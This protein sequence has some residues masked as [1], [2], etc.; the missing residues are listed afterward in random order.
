MSTYFCISCIIDKSMDM[1]TKITMGCTSEYS[2]KLW[3]DLLYFHFRTNVQQH[4]FLNFLKFFK[5]WHISTWKLH[6]VWGSR[7]LFLHCSVI[8]LARTLEYFS[9]YSRF[10]GLLD[11]HNTV[12]ENMSIT[13]Y[14]RWDKKVVCKKEREL[15]FSEGTFLR[16][17]ASYWTFPLL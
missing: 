12:S 8:K 3:N 1:I 7:K 2:R 17:T 10:T 11:P 4:Y 5:C 13:T 14:L 9:I 15:L 6:S 16:S